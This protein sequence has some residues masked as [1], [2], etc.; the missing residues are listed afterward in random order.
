MDDPNDV[1][2][3][4]DDPVLDSINLKSMS[5]GGTSCTLSVKIAINVED[6]G[7]RREK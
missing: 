2:D 3:I 6:F 5:F 7:G 4:G 1:V